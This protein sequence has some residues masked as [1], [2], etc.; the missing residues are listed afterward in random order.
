MKY[1]T[2]VEIYEKLEKTTLKLKKTKILSELFKKIKTN[3]IEEITLLSMGRVFP[4]WS[5]E[6]IGIASQ[7]M[8]KSISK[9]SGISPPKIEEEWK[10]RG[11]LGLVAEELISKKRQS[12]LFKG[13]LTTKKVF[14]NSR[15]LATL[16]GARSQEKKLM[17]ISELLTSASPKEAKYVTRTVLGDLRIGVGE[18][19]LRDSIVWAFFGKKLRL[20]YDKKEKKISMN[21]RKEYNDITEKVQH[22]YNLTIDFGLV[23]KQIKNKGLKGLD[24]LKLEVG[25]PVNVMLFKKA[26]DLEDAFKTVGKP[27]AIEHKYDGFRLHIHRNKNNISLFTRRSENVTN[28]FPDIVEIVKNNLKSKNYILDAEVIGIDPKTKKWLPFQKISRRIKRKYEIQKIID[29]VPVMVNV[30]DA[31]LINKKNLINEP[32]KKRRKEIEKIVKKV[33]NKLQCANQL[34]TSNIKE[35]NKFYKESLKKGNE[36]IMVKNL[37]GIYKPGSRVGYGV[38][39]KPIMESLDLVIIGAEWGTGKRA[40][41]LS[42]FILACRDAETGE[43]SGIGKMGTGIKEKKEEGTSF[44]EL[45]KRLKPFVTKEKGKKVEIKPSLVIEVGYEEIQKSPNYLSGFALRFPRLIRVRED[46]S[47]KEIDDLTRI[48]DLYN[49]QRKK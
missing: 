4:S 22:A 23:I 12:T 47:P 45:T 19:I 32:F 9:A 6:E 48:K 49:K 8:I 29:E 11:D 13:E 44:E 42:S 33:P 25:K 39:V 30:F 18:G 31:I 16:T 21:N 5:A 27:A 7:L 43:Y 35:A 17:L 1:K 34:I 40:N 20:E 14:E 24:E 37:E 3:D 38:K 28:Q 46:R 15:K 41:W 26:K 2:L 36:G 10:K